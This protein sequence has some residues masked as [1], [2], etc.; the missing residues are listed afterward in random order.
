MKYKAEVVINQQIARQF[1]FEK[2]SNPRQ[3]ARKVVQEIK[4]KFN[5]YMI[6]IVN[7]SGEAWS[8]SV[9]NIEGKKLIRPIEKYQM[10]FSKNDIDMI[11]TGNKA[12]V[13]MLL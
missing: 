9:K 12:I 7:D 2:L 10:I 6:L 11:F 1:Y 8:F 4:N 5:Y 3:C 13:G